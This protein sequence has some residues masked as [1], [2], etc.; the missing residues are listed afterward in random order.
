MMWV[1]VGSGG[2]AASANK[3]QLCYDRARRHNIGPFRLAPLEIRRDMKLRNGKRPAYHFIIA[4]QRR[5][6][7]GAPRKRPSR[8]S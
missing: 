2:L 8:S 1:V 6:T 5:A 7:P 4:I 3:L